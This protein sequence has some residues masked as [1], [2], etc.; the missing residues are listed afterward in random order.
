MTKM[1]FFCCINSFRC[2]R[3]VYSFL[4]VGHVHY[5]LPDRHS[6]QAIPSSQYGQLLGLT[7]ISVCHLWKLGRGDLSFSHL[8]HFMPLLLIS[9]YVCSNIFQNCSKNSFQQRA[10][11]CGVSGSSV[12]ECVCVLLALVMERG[13]EDCQGFRGSSTVSLSGV[14]TANTHSQSTSCVIHTQH[15]LKDWP[16]SDGYTANELHPHLEL[17]QIFETLSSLM[18]WSRSSSSPQLSVEM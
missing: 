14:W 6:Y 10:C 12:L 11:V 1:L 16:Q 15:T 7:D 9:H 4:L 13:Q 5:L 3:S 18:V 17:L 2:A 8:F